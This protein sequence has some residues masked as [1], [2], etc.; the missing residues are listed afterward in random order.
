MASNKSL[1]SLMKMLLVPSSL[2]SQSSSGL[3]VKIPS[4]L[5]PVSFGGKD[6]PAS[7]TTG[8]EGVQFGVAPSSATKVPTPT[9]SV[10]SSLLSNAL[11]GGVASVLGGGG[12]LSD[13]LSVFGGKGKTAPPA[14]VA[15][16]LPASQEQI[17]YVSSKGSN[18][19][20][21]TNVEQSMPTNP[22]SSGGQYQPAPMTPADVI[23]TVKNSI[24]NSGTLNDVIAD[25]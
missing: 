23:A 4:S 14:L 9:T 20:Q 11:S 6:R 16:Q 24:L 19:Y 25:V 2:T 12:L 13:L 1:T 7:S 22:A 10:F 5:K 17:V 3:S 15:F 8:A 21:G 18:V